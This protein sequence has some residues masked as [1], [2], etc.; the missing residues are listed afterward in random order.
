MTKMM[1]KASLDSQRI[2]AME[3]VIMQQSKLELCEM[4]MDMYDDELKAERKDCDMYRERAI[5]AEKRAKELAE[6]ISE[7]RKSE[8]ERDDAFERYVE[9]NRQYRENM[10]AIHR[11]EI[12]M[13][14]ESNK[15]LQE[16]Y[17]KAFES[18][19]LRGRIS[20]MKAKLKE[21]AIGRFF[22][23]LAEGQ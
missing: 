12:E 23:R 13:L 15:E 17:E 21:N 9:L 8:E 19:T 3:T 18:L 20:R 14:K 1:E 2:R 10:E 4:F 22:R 7:L 11:N 16:I 5:E 6:E